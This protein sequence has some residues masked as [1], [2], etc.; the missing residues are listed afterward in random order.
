MFGSAKLSVI[1]TTST[2]ASHLPRAVG[3]AQAIERRRGHA[4]PAAGAIA[5]RRNASPPEE[6]PED[7]I[8]VCSF[9][10]AS[11]NHSVA[12][13][14]FNTAGY[15][16][17]QGTRVPVLFICEDNGLGISVPSPAGCAAV[18]PP[19]RPARAR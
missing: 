10:D 11:I 7:A 9:G 18:P 16:D 6:W 5:A 12:V 3:L 15:L 1:P 4:Q 17:H 8:V 2:I 14:A 13:G 19:S